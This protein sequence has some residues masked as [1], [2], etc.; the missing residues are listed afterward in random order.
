MSG[1]SEY[2]T[3]VREINPECRPGMLS[4]LAEPQGC[5]LIPFLCLDL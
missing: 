4:L 1:E 2:V 5:H 3:D